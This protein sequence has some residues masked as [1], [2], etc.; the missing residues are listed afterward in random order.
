LLARSFRQRLIFAAPSFRSQASATTPIRIAMRK[1]RGARNQRSVNFARACLLAILFIPML[2]EKAPAA[3]MLAAEIPQRIREAI[4]Q[5]NRAVDLSHAGRPV[6]AEPL[7]SAALD[8]AK[9]DQI[10]SA[11]IATNL[12]ELYR[13][14][15][16]FS[17]ADRMFRL[18]LKWRRM[19]LPESSVDL[20]YA[21]NNLGEIYRVEGRVWEARNLM[22]SA[23][24]SLER[25]HPEAPGLPVVLSNVAIIWCGFGEYQRAEESLRSALA[26]YERLHNTSTP[27]YAIA[28][29]DL[30]QVLEAQDQLHAAEPLYAQAIGL[31]ESA[32]PVARTGLAA[33]LAGQGEL[34]QRLERPEQARETEQRALLLLHPDADALL[35]VQ[36]LRALGNIVAGGSKPA[37]SVPY[38]QQSLTIQEKTLGTGHPGTPGLLLDYASATQRAGNKSLARKLRKRAQELMI[39]LSAELPGRMTVSLR[40]LH[41]TQ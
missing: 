38:F 33:A 12:G 35:H 26:A 29:M 20:A 4:L 17:D 6:E 22:E 23:A 31:F 1:N 21:L 2:A 27:D 30:G 11:R 15:D 13:K 41:D 10:L 36:I 19:N 9:E 32:G 24:Q 34:Y 7:F 40:Q 8:G 37:D 39:H 25:F 14:E 3:E 28:L 5:N 16:R 18:A